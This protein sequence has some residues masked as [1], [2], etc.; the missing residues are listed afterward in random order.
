[1]LEVGIKGAINTIEAALSQGV[2]RYV[3][4]STSETYGEPTH[5]PT[6]ESEMLKIAD[7]TNPRFSYGGG[8]IAS[9]LLTLHLAARRGLEVVI[10][11]PHNF[12]GP[13]MGV[14]HVVPEITRRIVTLSG[15]LRQKSIELPIQGD[16]FDTR[17]FCF[18]SDG[19]RGASVVGNQGVSGGIYNVGTDRETTVADLVRLI[20]ESVGIDVTIVPGERPS[21]SPPRR[22]PDITK[23]RAL[24]FEPEVSLEEGIRQ[25]SNW[26]AED[27]MGRNIAEVGLHA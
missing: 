15:G 18:V 21:G 9:E 10:F 24:G 8:K 17:S 23:L 1:V 6:D 16:G 5:V 13:D 12:Y 26:Y 4:A 25:T 7:V 14:E 11:R 19:A 27:L 22:C 20:G 3:L 2:R